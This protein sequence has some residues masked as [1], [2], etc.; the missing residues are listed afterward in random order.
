MQNVAQGEAKLSRM[1]PYW[2]IFLIAGLCVT[3]YLALFNNGFRQIFTTP[4]ESNE[5]PPPTLTQQEIAQ[6]VL[7]A[8]LLGVSTIEVAEH[9]KD[10]IQKRK[11]LEVDIAKEKETYR[12]LSREHGALKQRHVELGKA[13]FDQET[14]TKA[15]AK[16]LSTKVATRAGKSVARHVAG[17]A[18]ESIPVVGTAL[19]AG[20]LA[21]DVKDACDLMKEVNEM[22][23]ALGVPK[24]DEQ[25]ICG[26][27]VPSR[28]ELATS[29]TINWKQAYQVAAEA[30]GTSPTLPVVSWPDLKT[31]MCSLLQTGHVVLGVKIC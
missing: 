19:I 24:E 18:G 14:R 13:K 15:A 5:P 1:P 20:M 25:K 27:Q 12:T 23:Q 11:N 7:T 26:V 28:A 3:N 8:G 31:P 6:L 29:V 10:L 16:T 21:L 2:A 9:V 17:A 30:I 22:N 4:L